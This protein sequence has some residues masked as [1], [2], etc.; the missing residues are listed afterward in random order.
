MKFRETA[1]MDDTDPLLYTGPLID[2][3]TGKLISSDP[4]KDDDK[5]LHAG[6]EVPDDEIETSPIAQQ[7]KKAKTQEAVLEW[8]T[9]LQNEFDEVVGM[10]FGP[11]EGEA[12]TAKEL[13]HNSQQ[14]SDSY[15]NMTIGRN[16]VENKDKGMSKIK[17]DTYMEAGL[18]EK[19]NPKKKYTTYG[20][21]DKGKKSPPQPPPDIPSKGYHA[22]GSP[23]GMQDSIKDFMNLGASKIVLERKKEMD[24]KIASKSY[25]QEPAKEEKLNESPL[26]TFNKALGKKQLW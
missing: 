22:P 11:D 12:V 4:S 8:V 10:N 19:E 21:A 6:D 23:K 9:V 25:V 16:L 2:P 17:D 14:T 3:K 15:L 24:E 26:K 20:E 1:E 13:A 5:E 7:T 18:V